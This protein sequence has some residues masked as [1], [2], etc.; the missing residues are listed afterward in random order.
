[1]R[2]VASFDSVNSSETLFTKMLRPILEVFEALN[3]MFVLLEVSLFVVACVRRSS[4]IS[5]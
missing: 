5:K 4:K 1:M 2:S 3:M